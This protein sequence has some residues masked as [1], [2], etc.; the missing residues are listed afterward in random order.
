MYQWLIGVLITPGL[1]QTFNGSL[2]YAASPLAESILP[3]QVVPVRWA[4]VTKIGLE[5]GDEGMRYFL[6][7]DGCSGECNYLGLAGG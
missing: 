6:E 3:T 5:D 4:P 2:M 1:C 7:V